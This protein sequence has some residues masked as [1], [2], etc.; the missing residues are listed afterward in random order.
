VI[1][2][3]LSGLVIFFGLS[4]A[5]G[6]GL[7]WWL[8][9]WGV[10]FP[11]N[12]HETVAPDLP[13]GLSDPAFLLFTKTNSFRHTE[14]IAA[15]TTLFESLA[16]EQGLAMF[17]TENSAVFNA[18]DLKRFSA[19]VFLNVTGDSLSEAQREAFQ[20]WL[21][22]GGGWLGIHAA[23]DGSH[24][25]WPWYVENV[26]GV[27][28]TAHILGPRFQAADIVSEAPGH[29]VMGELPARWSHTEEW[30][31]WRESPREKG[32]TVLARVD[33]TTYRPVQKIFNREVDLRMG[34]H[35]VTWLRCLGEGRVV[36]T[37]MGHAGEAY[38]QPRFRRL[39]SN[40]LAWTTGEGACVGHL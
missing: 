3:L 4:L 16:R 25:Y 13:A 37:A 36:Y 20:Q 10:L 30:Y 21:T 28:F 17:H 32:F 22:A 14:G 26:I 27:E 15:G 5:A 38:S 12:A 9:A 29:P 39:L 2:K 35:P 31:S 34:D 11:S 18:D 7:A 23:G 40:A 33:E 6:L 8:G 19:V 1:S 24:S